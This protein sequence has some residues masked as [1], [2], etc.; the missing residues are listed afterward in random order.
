[1]AT[2]DRETKY[3][4]GQGVVLVG[5]YD[6]SGNV[7]GLEAVGNV[8]DLKVRI[9]TSVTE[10]KENQSGQR[11]VDFRLTTET[12]ANLTMTLENFSRDT[13]AMALRGG[14]TAIAAGEATAAPIK[15]YLGKVVSLP[16]VKV[17]DVVVKKA[18]TTLVAYTND[19]TPYDYQLN[20]DAGSI[21][22]AATPTTSGLVDGDD[23]TVDYDYAA[24]ARVDALTENPRPRFLRFEG[25]N[26]LDGNNPVI[27]EAFRFTVDP[28]KEL[29]LIS[30][31]DQAS[32]ELE[33]SLLA[34][35]SRTTGSKFFRQLLVR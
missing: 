31:E 9:E 5:V 21:K 6:A 23:L 11:A 27:V 19:T 34:D 22:F 1:M 2:W 30:G 3:Y 10:H 18:T 25:L 8:T 15:A 12:K 24:Q 35:A 20:A 32:F 7:T 33:G 26:T 29:A 14:Y 17:S 4:S 13:L 16:H 28:A